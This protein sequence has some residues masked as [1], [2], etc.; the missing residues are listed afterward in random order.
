MKIQVKLFKRFKPVTGKLQRKVTYRLYPTPGQEAKMLD[1]SSLRIAVSFWSRLLRGNPEYQAVYLDDTGLSIDRRDSI[2]RIGFDS[3]DSIEARA[4]W[5][6]GRLLIT[7]VDGRVQAVE[8]FGKAAACRFTHIAQQHQTT[9]LDAWR[10]ALAAKPDIDRAHRVIVT[11]TNGSQY[12]AHA[13]ALA[14]KRLIEPVSLQLALKPA[15]FPQS[16][17]L[18]RKL[19]V[20]RHFQTDSARLCRENNAAFVAAEVERF[21]DYFDTVEKHPLTPRQREAVVTHEDNTLVIAGAGSGKT[22]VIAAKAGYLL[23]KGLCSPEELLLL[24]FSKDAKQDMANRLRPVIRKLG[25]AFDVEIA[26]YTFHALG[27]D[28]ISRVTGKRPPVADEARDR[29]QLERLVHDSLT[30]LATEPVYHELLRTYFQSFFA[31]Y[32]SPFDFQTREDYDDYVRHHELRT[33]A[34]EVVKSFE[35]CEIANFLYLNGVAYH[36]ETPYEIDNTDAEFGQYR[37]DFYL[38]ESRIYIEHFALDQQGKAPPYFAGYVEGVLWKRALHAAHQTR[39]LETYSY[40]KAQGCLTEVLA[41]QL[42]DAGVIFHPIPAHRMF[43]K[44][45]ELG[46]ID[47]FTRLVG[48]FLRHFKANDSTIQALR[49]R[50]GGSD[51][52]ASAFLALFEPVYARYESK[53]AATGAIDFEDMIAR[54]TRYASQQRFKSPYRCILVD[55]FQDI[56]AGRAAL[57]RALLDQDPSYRLFAVGDDWQAIYRFTGSD[58]ALMRRFEHHFGAT[59][60]VTLDRTFRFNNQ[61]GDVAA[62][63]VL[64]NPLQLPKQM[65][66]HRNVETPQVF[67][68]RRP[69][70]DT[71]AVAAALTRIQARA[72]GEAVTVKLLGRYTFDADFDKGGRLA[73]LQTQF[74]TLTLE[75]SSIHRAKGLEADYVV[76]LNNK[77]G[78]YGFPSGVTDDPLL[79]WVLA[80][81]EP[82]PFAE[83]RR[84]LYVA[85]TRARHA[86]YL[87][88]PKS[89]RDWS[90]FARELSSGDGVESI[91][92]DGN[93]EVPC[94]V[95]NVG[96]LVKRDG[97]GGLFYGC[98]EY[99][100]CTECRVGYFI[101]AS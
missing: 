48:T 54:A 6:W 101:P 75:M 2:E 83:E 23:K 22:S 11:L 20:L 36:Y 80:E 52:R 5:I 67:I 40:Q 96:A 8:G 39:L 10:Q 4:G 15:L 56:S 58:T 88:V 81:P 63:F 99:P 79:G 57:L 90:V 74:P 49:H 73:A 44:L 45:R 53:L 24:A 87:T 61:I 91:T 9:F 62:R 26:V 7:R 17:E 72:A 41:R 92:A 93:P 42:M 86:V 21:R 47:P 84:L 43:E 12:A 25:V 13:V 32:E 59:A 37:P 71:D 97:N 76:V 89:T 19:A 34:G 94:P 82:Y 3:I 98:S 95:C 27:V 46:T 100:D 69:E 35:E 66:S 77:V 18:G 14:A 65:T 60:T 55:E 16:T 78:R 70:G 50:I 33:L 64:K 28:I 31:P 51:A 1:M 30:E 85:L 68:L 29:K 38:P